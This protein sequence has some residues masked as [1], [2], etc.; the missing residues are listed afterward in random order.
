MWQQYDIEKIYYV[1]SDNE[2][3]ESWMSI[4]YFQCYIHRHI[5][6]SDIYV[7]FNYKFDSAKKQ[8]YQKKKRKENATKANNG[9]L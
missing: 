3:K 4:I 1:S 9:I 5:I 8:I 2:L 6:N 7:G